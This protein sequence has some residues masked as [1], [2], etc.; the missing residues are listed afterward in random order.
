MT[1]L[2][3][4]WICFSFI[5]ISINIQNAY[6]QLN[7]SDSLIIKSLNA[8]NITDA[9]NSPLP[10]S[11]R[12]I[13]IKYF[14]VNGLKPSDYYTIN[15]TRIQINDEKGMIAYLRIGALRDK[16]NLEH[17]NEPLLRLGSLG[18]DGDE[19]MVVYNH[20]FSEITGITNSE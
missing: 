16:Y 18:G 13:T 17:S 7:K 6:C 5:F 1:R 12:K 15:N 9:I 4:I 14:I 3:I 11:I 19:I 20:C 2:R 8:I 10:D